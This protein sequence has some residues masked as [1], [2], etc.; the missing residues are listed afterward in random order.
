LHRQ[1][2]P[3]YH[4]PQQ[5]EGPNNDVATM[6]SASTVSY[7]QV[8]MGHASS[9]DPEPMPEL[10]GVSDEGC[11]IPKSLPS[12]EDDSSTTPK[13]IESGSNENSSSS[14]M[15][16]SNAITE[17]DGD[18]GHVSTDAS[19]LDGDKTS[20]T[21]VN[22]HT[23][24]SDT[25]ASTLQPH[26]HE[27]AVSSGFNVDRST[28]DDGEAKDSARLELTE[29][30]VPQFNIWQQRKEAQLAKLRN[31]SNSES[32]TEIGMAVKND[33]KSGNYD[34]HR[35]GKPV[36]GRGGGSS[37]ALTATS[38]ITQFARYK[39]GETSRSDGD[40]GRRSHPRG[41]KLAEKDAEVMASTLLAISTPLTEVPPPV[42][43]ASLWPTLD[44][45]SKEEKRKATEKAE[46]TTEK[47]HIDEAIAKPRTSRGWRNVELDYRV[48]FPP[49]AS[50]TRN[51]RGRAGSRGGSRA[52]H[53]QTQGVAQ[54]LTHGSSSASD[55]LD[56]GSYSTLSPHKSS[57]V[58]STAKTDS[59]PSFVA[60]DRDKEKE[61]RSVDAFDVNGSTDAPGFVGTHSN[62]AVSRR[63]ATDG[64]ISK[65]GR[66]LVAH[67][68]LPGDRPRDH[69][70]N[71]MTSNLQHLRERSDGRP[72][73]G[74][75]TFRG[76]GGHHGMAIA[77]VHG[78]ANPTIGEFKPQANLPTRPLQYS[79]QSKQNGFTSNLQTHGNSSHLG[80]VHSNGHARA[81]GGHRSSG[82]SA[83]HNRTNSSTIG[84]FP[85]N[86][87][88]AVNHV[89]EFPAQSLMNNV[90]AY[91]LNV[92]SRSI[93]PDAYLLLKAQLEY[94]FSVDNLCKDLFLRKH[95][96]T[97]GFVP[98]AVVAQFK[99]L[100]E[101]TD[102][103]EI[104]GHACEES[105]KLEIITLAD[106]TESVRATNDWHP[107]VL[108]VSERQH[109][110]QHGGPTDLIF[111]SRLAMG[112]SWYPPVNGYPLSSTPT[113]MYGPG[114]LDTQFRMDPTHRQNGS[115][116]TNAVASNVGAYQMPDTP[117][118]ATVPAFSPKIASRGRACLST[119]SSQNNGPPDSSSAAT[120]LPPAPQM[121]AADESL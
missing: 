90:Q 111:R 98:L 109:S 83:S 73:R 28:V 76:R 93:S 14:P 4:N 63:P 96:D 43:D 26:L 120:G 64:H 116:P 113:A 13:A 58:S 104:L 70:L 85:A 81:R 121:H 119:P 91:P 12:G 34:Q 66:K 103:I 82:P 2:D 72:D 117:L 48:M 22:T 97:Q 32:S 52:S 80:S 69:S 68:P 33:S 47:E 17:G 74:R 110:A 24:Q 27:Q 39:R 67:A 94:Y 7:A 107:F 35:A 60:R 61:K 42:D 78:S 77:H 51:P 100:R 36:T 62:S 75:G 19:S 115:V 99:R 45:A 1:K 71:S 38:G 112:S 108:P 106:G 11:R 15:F 87:P 88:M 53:S 102:D 114:S 30:P 105:G 40:M 44:G 49:P 31:T 37:S 20:T 101:I 50:T 54:S 95:M 84:A 89:Y 79:P 56:G 18:D 118:S 23:P 59:D 92:Y 3:I 10:R 6:S 46:R 5:L 21:S 29:A 9:K 16:S 86:Q 41:N 8:A 25:P 65:E 55:G 57:V